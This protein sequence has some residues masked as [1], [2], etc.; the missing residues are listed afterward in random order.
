MGSNG[1]IRENAHNNI[2]KE[3]FDQG[4]D[5]IFKAVCEICNEIDKKSNMIKVDN[6]DSDII[7][8]HKDC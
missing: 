3:K 1:I 7:Y 4:Y 2:D 8:Y 6:E 5:R